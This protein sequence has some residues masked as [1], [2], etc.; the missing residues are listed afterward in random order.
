M[1]YLVTR[2]RGLAQSLLPPSTGF[3]PAAHLPPG[4]RHHSAKEADHAQ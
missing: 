2:G 4:G 3:D 1:V